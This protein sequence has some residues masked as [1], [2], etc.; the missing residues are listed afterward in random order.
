M[1]AYS[2]HVKRE[3]PRLKD[4]LPAK[5]RVLLGTI[6]RAIPMIKATMIMAI[7][8]MTIMTTTFVKRVGAAY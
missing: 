3:F 2:D 8:T 7:T 5:S 6:I 4:E 1:A